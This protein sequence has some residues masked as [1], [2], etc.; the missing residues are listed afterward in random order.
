MIETSRTATCATTI[1]CRRDEPISEQDKGLSRQGQTEQAKC[2][3]RTGDWRQFHILWAS[4]CRLGSECWPPRRRP[5]SVLSALLAGGRIAAG[6]QSVFQNTFSR[7]HSRR[8]W[9]APD[10]PSWCFP[11]GRNRPSPPSL[12]SPSS[13]DFPNFWS[14]LDERC[15]TFCFPGFRGLKAGMLW[16]RQIQPHET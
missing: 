10:R 4:W 12:Q 3:N 13:P 6:S 16:R 1:C 8:R 7:P 15:W 5:S 11:V 9:T 14:S 2:C